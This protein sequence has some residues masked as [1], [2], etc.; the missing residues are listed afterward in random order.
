RQEDGQSHTVILV[1]VE[2]ETG[3]YQSVRDFSPAA[4]ALF[5]GPAPAALLQALHKP[6]GT[7]TQVFGRDADEFF[8]AWCVARYVEQVAQA[9]KA[10]YA[11]PLYANAALRD[12]IKYQDPNTY[13]SG[14]PTWNVIDI[15][16]AAA[17]SLAL[18]A[19][20][21]YARDYPT[22]AAH[23]ARYARPDNPLM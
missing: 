9:G 3:T 1:Q 15:W 6:P 21:I 14:G 23:F 4:N 19:P 11:L 13:S 16:K 12:P 5:A 22:V 10:E 7:W 18:L 20:D 17:P 2:N 8:H